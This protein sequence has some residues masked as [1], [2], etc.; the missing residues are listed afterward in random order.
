LEDSQNHKISIPLIQDSIVE[1]EN[2][3]I[4]ESDEEEDM[5]EADLTYLHGILDKVI[6]ILY[7]M[8]ILYVV[9]IAY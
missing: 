7:I 9:L 6:I 2:D 4:I 5:Y 1:H 8:R 3:Y